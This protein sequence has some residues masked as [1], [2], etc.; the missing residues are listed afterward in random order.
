MSAILYFLSN[1]LI[2]NLIILLLGL[3]LGWFIWARRSKGGDIDFK[4]KYEAEQTKTSNLQSQL[5]AC[6]KARKNM[7]ADFGKVEGDLGLAKGDITSGKSRIAEL[8][9]ELAKAKDSAGSG[10]ASSD[11]E[12]VEAKAKITDLE[13]LE[14]GK[15]KQDEKY[16]LLYTEAVAKDEQD[17]LTKIHGV[18]AVLNKTLNDYGVYKYRQIALWTPQICNDFSERISFKGRI[19]RDNWIG[20]CKQF[21]EEKYGEKI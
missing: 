1:L 13:S 10:N 3:L 4:A 15:L 21:H 14:S 18:A 7:E 9:A 12:L 8:E 5:D 19:E 16:G 20:Q 11:A 2:H 6:K 17:D